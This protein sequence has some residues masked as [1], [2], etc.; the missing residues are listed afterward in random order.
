MFWELLSEPQRSAA[1]AL[2]YG[3]RTWDLGDTPAECR[4]FWEEMSQP[5]LVYAS[6]LG[7]TQESWDEEWTSVMHYY[8][9]SASLGLDRVLRNDEANSIGS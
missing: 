5:L 9:F 6:M 2:G 3:A 7:Y 1:I 8:A 4:L